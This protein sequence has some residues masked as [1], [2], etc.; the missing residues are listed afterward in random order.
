M[1]VCFVTYLKTKSKKEKLL[2]IA[3]INMAK[4]SQIA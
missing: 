3:E 4:K 2:K 1:K